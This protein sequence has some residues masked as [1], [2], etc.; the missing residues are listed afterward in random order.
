MSVVREALDAGEKITWV[1]TPNCF[2]LLCVEAD[3]A[4]S[5][6]KL[7][8]LRSFWIV[9]HA[10][11]GAR[12]RC[13]RGLPQAEVARGVAEET[14]EDGQPPASGAGPRC[15]R[16]VRASGALLAASGGRRRD[17][18]TCCLGSKWDDAPVVPRHPLF[19][20]IHFRFE[21]QQPVV[22]LEPASVVCDG[23]RGPKGLQAATGL[24]CMKNET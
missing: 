23:G 22:G 15:A 1:S 3:T 10:A 2:C 12:P 9:Y 7:L 11:R 24:Y 17:R 14:G 19:L 6:A 20:F 21:E 18:P 5:T 8:C 13:L 4:F 16:P